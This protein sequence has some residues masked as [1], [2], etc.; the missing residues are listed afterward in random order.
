MT[1]ILQR[2]KIINANFTAKKDKIVV[3]INIQLT[4]VQYSCIGW[5]S[6]WFFAFLPEKKQFWHMSK[7]KHFKHRYLE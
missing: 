6:L 5:V 7:L 2:R 3:N 4:A 1:T